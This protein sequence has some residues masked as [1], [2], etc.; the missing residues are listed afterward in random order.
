MIMFSPI[1]QN[2]QNL[3]HKSLPCWVAQFPRLLSSLHCL[4]VK[5]S[6]QTVVV[7]SLVVVGGGVV[8]VV[9]LV[10]VS[11]QPQQ[12]GAAVVVLGQ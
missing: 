3:G 5:T 7:G 10:V 1:P 2:S 8:V 4:K 11:E 12:S 9:V 6:S